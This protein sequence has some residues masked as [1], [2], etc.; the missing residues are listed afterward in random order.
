MRKM[1]SR[2]AALLGVMTLLGIAVAAPSGAAG[3]ATVAPNPIPVSAGQE[4]ATVT[5]DYNF[6]GPNTVI[7]AA[8][9]FAVGS[10]IWYN[11]DG[12]RTLRAASVAVAL[13]LTVFAVCE[14]DRQAVVNRELDRVYG[15]IP[16]SR[17]R[18]RL[19]QPKEFHLV[20]AR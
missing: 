6:G 10:A 3:S 12:H 20:P 18:P 8:V 1:V 7:A 9:L 11:L 17:V 2:L 13:L 5:V 19:Y 15:A 14:Q 16:A 4:Y